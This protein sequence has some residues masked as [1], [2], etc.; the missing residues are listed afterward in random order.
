[1]YKGVVFFDYDGT[2]V[3]ESDNISKPTEKTIESFQKL[4]D[5]GYM[6]AVCSGRPYSQLPKID[7]K[8][9][10]Y[11]NS[12]GASVRINDEIIFNSPFELEYTLKMIDFFKNNDLTF[13]CETSNL[14]YFGDIHTERIDK[15]CKLFNVPKESYRPLNELDT[16]L[17]KEIVKIVVLFPE[18]KEKME[19]ILKVFNNEFSEKF[20]T[21][22]QL[23]EY[24]ID[25]AKKGFSKAVGIK[26]VIEKFNFDLKDTYAFGDGGNDKEMIEFVGNGIVMGKHNPILN[27]IGDYYTDTVKNEGITK[28]LLHYKLI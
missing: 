1:M 10:C 28:G 18:D 17:L 16:D 22:Q 4:R 12:N 6:T 7:F 23:Y 13:Y 2:M 21:F 26:A 9:D 19:N 5:N 15:N 8:F 25:I 11:V 14:C 27:N 20:V 24:G 3:D